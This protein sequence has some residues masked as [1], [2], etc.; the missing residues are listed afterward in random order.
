MPAGGRRL[1]GGGGVWAWVVRVR[2][3]VKVRRT[4]SVAAARERMGKEFFT[5]DG[6]DETDK[7]RE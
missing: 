5:A 2:G 3:K 4:L 6:T 1:A 7:G